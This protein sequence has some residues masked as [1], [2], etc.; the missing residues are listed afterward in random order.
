MSESDTRTNLSLPEHLAECHQA[1]SLFDKNGDGSIS[2]SE[3]GSVMRALGSN[4]SEEDVA[5]LISR[6]DIDG[7]G[8]I[9]FNEFMALMLPNGEEALTEEA[10][11]LSVFRDLDK[12]G[13]GTISADELRFALRALG[14][15]MS[16]D[17]I[18]VLL[19]KTDTD[20]DGR[21]NYQEFVRM[22]LDT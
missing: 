9:E 21:V 6:L 14:E 20:G 15:T 2:A 8:T 13:D 4:P 10:D 16:D 3:L 18:D 1:F 17:D 12:N 7:N 5:G 22:I 11:L 19:K